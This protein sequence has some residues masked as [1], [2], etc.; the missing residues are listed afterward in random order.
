[1]SICDDINAS[2]ARFWWGDGDTY[3]KIHWKSWQYLGKSKLDGGLRFRD[4]SSFNI[5]LLAKQCW[6]LITE[7]DSLWARVIKARYFPNCDFTKAI[8]G[9]RA[10]WS[11][12]GLIE[13]R[14]SVIAGAIW[15]VE[16]S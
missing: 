3:S 11:W 10:S 16:N 9:Y 15:Q 8:K 6:G 4:L 14:D 2:L 1:M 12:S 5:A 7:P 13:A